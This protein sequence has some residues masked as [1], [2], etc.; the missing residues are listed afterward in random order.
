[1]LHIIK[2][3][4]CFEQININES[5]RYFMSLTL[6]NAFKGITSIEAK[7]NN[8][9][10]NV[11]G[12]SLATGKKADIDPVSSFLGKNLG[13]DAFLQREILSDVGYCSNVLKLAGNGASFISS[14]LANM[15]AIVAKAESCFADNRAVLNDMLQQQINQ[16]VET[17][18]D[19]AFNGKR[20]LDG[21]FGSNPSIR[22]HYNTKAIDVR[23]EGVGSGVN[24]ADK[25]AKDQRTIDFSDPARFAAIAHGDTIVLR[26]EKF[27]LVD[28]VPQNENEVAIGK[29]SAEMAS[30]LTTAIRNSSAEALRA[31]NVTAR[32]GQTIITQRSASP[33]PIPLTV[34]PSIDASSTPS[35]I[36]FECELWGAGCGIG[37]QIMLAGETFTFGNEPGQVSPTAG[38]NHAHEASARNLVAAIQNN[39][40]T[41][42]LIEQGF[43]TV[44]ATSTGVVTI[45]S[46]LSE[47]ILGFSAGSAANITNL[48]LYSDLISKSKATTYGKTLT[49]TTPPANGD[50]VNVNGVAFT[51]GTNWDGSILNLNDRIIRVNPNNLIASGQLSLAVDTATRKLTFYSDVD[52]GLQYVDAAPPGPGGS[53][54]VLTNAAISTADTSVLRAAIDV[55]EIRNI[56]GF[57]GTPSVH[58]E[59]ISEATSA[60]GDGAAAALHMQVAGHLPPTASA[61][62]DSF[63]VV[64]AKVSGRTFQ[65]LVWK[66]GSAANIDKRSI[67]FKE[68]GTSEAFTVNTGTNN[69]NPTMAAL[70]EDIKTLF[71]TT[72]FAQTRDLELYTA[73]GQII[74]ETATVIGDVTGMTASLN[75]TD[76]NGKNFQDF[77]ITAA[78]GGGV[79]FT[80]TIND[81][82]FSTSLAV[83][84][85]S[86]GAALKLHN[87][88]SGDILVINLGKG[89]LDALGDAKN[90]K[91]IELAMKKSLMSIGIGL[92]VK[93][94]VDKKTIVQI[95]D[96]S[97]SK[98]YRDNN[99]N[100][101]QGINLL[102]QE[103]IRIAHEVITNALKYAR[104]AE[105][106]I[107]GN[108]K[109]IAIHAERLTN[110]GSI[111]QELSDGYMNTDIMESATAFAEA[112]KRLLGAISVLEAGKRVT[113]T[114][115]RIITTIA[116]STSY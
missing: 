36:S 104:N 9:I 67:V 70:T 18:R 79:T 39:L 82:N 80:A 25:G 24:F 89:G 105:A 108:S 62:G 95:D 90:Y 66:E 46:T 61:D 33:A 93:T 2:I 27:T 8:R 69:Y 7:D 47:D 83:N 68:A 58:F 38:Y 76:F 64:E 11:H 14:T 50:T 32:N 85:L 20:L 71:S 110:T 44:S 115:G 101:I 106:K 65:A 52:L 3:I 77:K 48:N 112:E 63:A 86:E 43:L 12:E 116:A 22:T 107:M 84:E 100:Y 28:T 10:L 97:T 102:T 35:T 75:T 96:I 4:L 30:N 81:Q 34:P 41:K 114:A 17:T 49:L 57:I 56:E 40:N 16:V 54:G 29:T 59:V 60:A 99:G 19:T 98:L 73:G 1:M 31:Y 5:L 26:G 37:S 113:D 51:V 103:S 15:L 94:G 45:R 87:P 42:A 78:N 91:I 74:D 53:P 21:D 111:T 6:G 23:R 13:D 92:D 109:A 72:Q 88:E 55:S